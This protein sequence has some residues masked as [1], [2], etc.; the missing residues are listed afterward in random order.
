M[1]E[2]AGIEPASEDRS[3]QAST[4]VVRGFDPATR[5][6]HKQDHR[7]AHPSSFTGWARALPAGYSPVDDALTE[8]LETQPPQ[9]ELLS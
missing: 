6:P 1:V 2:A 8:A 9:D 3:M 5:A 7:A 4:C